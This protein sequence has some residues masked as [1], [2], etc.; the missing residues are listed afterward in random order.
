MIFR[1][2]EDYRSVAT[3]FV[4]L[5]LM[6]YGFINPPQTWWG[7][8]LLCAAAAEMSFVCAVISHNTL[9][10]PI[11]KPR[12]LNKAMQVLL[13]WATGDTVS[14][15]VPSHNLGHHTHLQTAK[16]SMRTSKLRFRWNFLNQLLFTFV[17]GG[18]VVKGTYRYIWAMR[19][20]KRTWFNQ[21]ALEAAALALVFL[22][23]PFIN[24]QSFLLYIMIPYVFS[25]WGIIGI[26]FIQHDGCDPNH[27]YNHSR[28]FVDPLTNWWTFNNGY[29]AMHHERPGMHWADLPAAHREQLSPHVHPS[30]E[31]KSLPMFLFKTFVWPG[32]RLTYD[33]KPLVLPDPIPDASWVPTPKETAPLAVSLGAES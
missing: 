21:W 28:S 19:K 16:D 3:V 20:R 27:R 9:H 13:T 10:V 25:S 22:T 7:M 15:F 4:T 2:R 17:V 23:L 14:A 32:K 18:D 29:H 6:A 12:P 26:N 1:R 33:G 24:L 5:G 8:L 30:L 11:F 31:Q